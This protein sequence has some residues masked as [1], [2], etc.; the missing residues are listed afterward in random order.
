MS[1]SIH[2]GGMIFEGPYHAFGCTKSQ[3]GFRL[4]NCFTAKRRI[5]G[6]TDYANFLLLAQGPTPCAESCQPCAD[7]R[8]RSL[9][10]SRSLFQS[11]W[12]LRKKIPSLLTYDYFRSFGHTVC[13]VF[14]LEMKESSIITN[15]PL[16]MPRFRKGFPSSSSA[17]KL[18]LIISQADW[19]SEIPPWHD[20][21]ANAGMDG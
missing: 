7:S 20:S 11:P 3:A 16:T 14:F 15:G 4:V 5:G 1:G 18:F 2:S 21:A 13:F 12:V 8:S 9:P 19:V 6:K 10:I 17:C